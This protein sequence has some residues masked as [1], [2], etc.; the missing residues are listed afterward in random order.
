MTDQELME[1]VKAIRD[2]TGCYTWITINFDA[3]ISKTENI[4]YQY[5]SNA[6]SMIDVFKT[7]EAL[8]A[9]LDG[10]LEGL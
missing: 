6:Q 4:E 5:S 3:F 2:K 10:I 1:K 7:R 9:H 8:V